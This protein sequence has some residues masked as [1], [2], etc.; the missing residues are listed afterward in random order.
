MQ[1]RTALTKCPAPST[2]V[3]E[4]ATRPCDASVSA[5]CMYTGLQREIISHITQSEQPDAHLKLFLEPQMTCIGLFLH[6]DLKSSAASLGVLLGG[7]P[8]S[9][10]GSLWAQARASCAFTQLRVTLGPSP[11]KRRPCNYI[12]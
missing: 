7:L 10:W 12:A 4:A 5:S 11:T 3:T 8:G 9:G 1:R 6:M 2:L